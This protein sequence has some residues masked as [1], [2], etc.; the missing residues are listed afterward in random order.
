[1]ASAFEHK[2]LKW[3]R[4]RFES[5]DVPTGHD[6]ARLIDSCHN[7]LA[8]SDVIIT[9]N[10]TV[11]GNITSQGEP[12]AGSQVTVNDPRLD[13]L[14]T[15]VQTNSATWQAGTLLPIDA[16]LKHLH[17]VFSEGSSPTSNDFQQLID[18]SHNSQAHTNPQIQNLLSL[19]NSKSATWGTG[20]DIS[21]LQSYILASSADW[22]QQTDIS[23]ITS[24]VSTNS[25]SWMRGASNSLE[26]IYSVLQPNSAAWSSNSIAID[27]LT[28]T[29]QTNSAI[30]TQAADEIDHVHWHVDNIQSYLQTN[31]AD[32]LAQTDVS[33]IASTIQTYSADWL[34]KTDISHLTSA[35]TTNSAAWLKQTDVTD[36]TSTLLANSGEWARKAALQQ[37]TSF[38][39]T[40][41]SDW[42]GQSQI[43]DLQSTVITSSA[44]WSEKTDT[45][46]LQTEIDSILNIIQ[47]SSSDWIGDEKVN[48]ILSLIDLNT[49]SSNALQFSLNDITTY[50]Q[51]VSTEWS[52][53]TTSVQ[54]NSSAWAQQ[55]DTTT[56]I[57]DV[58]S[59]FELTAD[60]QS[61]ASHVA[62]YSAS[63]AEKTDISELTN[64]VQDNSA[65]W[66]EQT[67]ITH[68]T[69]QLADTGSTVD[70]LILF[71]NSTSASWQEKTDITELTNIITGS[72]AAWM[73]KVDITKTTNDINNMLSLISTNTAR[74]NEKTDVSELTSTVQINSGDWSNATEIGSITDNIHDLTN[75]IISNSAAWLSKTNITELTSIVS[76]YSADWLVDTT[77]TALRSFVMDNSARWKI[78]EDEI[79]HIH[80]HVHD[81]EDLEAIVMAN[82]AKW[83]SCVRT[84]EDDCRLVP[85]TNFYVGNNVAQNTLTLASNPELAW[86]G[87]ENTTT[88]PYII[89]GSGKHSSNNS[90][91]I[92]LYYEWGENQTGVIIPRE[93]RGVLNIEME[94]TS[95]NSSNGTYGSVYAFVDYKTTADGAWKRAYIHNPTYNGFPVSISSGNIPSNHNV[96]THGEWWKQI[97]VDVPTNKLHSVRVRL[98]DTD[99]HANP[100]LKISQLD[101]IE[102]DIDIG[103]EILTYISELS[104]T[105]AGDTSELLSLVQTHSS[106]W[107]EQANLSEIEANLQQLTTEF[108]NVSSTVQNNSAYW[109]HTDITAIVAENSASWPEVAD[110]VEHVHWHVSNIETLLR[111]NSA[112]WDGDVEYVKTVV[113]DNSARWEQQTDITNII[114]NVNDITSYV[115]NNTASWE[116]QTDITNLVTDV[117]NLNI[118]TGDVIT[119]VLSN[120]SDWSRDEQL[121][122]LFMSNSGRWDTNEQ[123]VLDLAAQVAEN[124]ADVAQTTTYLQANTA[125]WDNS[126]GNKLGYPDLTGTSVGLPQL[127]ND[128][129]IPFTHFDSN[130]HPV[131]ESRFT[132]IAQRNADDNTEIPFELIYKVWYEADAWNV[133][134]GPTIEYR[135]LTNDGLEF[136]QNYP[137]PDTGVS[138][139][140]TMGVKLGDSIIGDPAFPND[141]FGYDIDM[142]ADG[143][144][145]IISR[146]GRLTN[147][148]TEGDKP[149]HVQVYR[150]KANADEWEQVGDDIIGTMTDQLQPRQVA[151]NDAGNRVAIGHSGEIAPGPNQVLGAVEIFEF[152]GT[153]WNPMGSV[154]YGEQ[155]GGGF[156]SDF[157]L[158]GAGDRIVIGARRNDSNGIDEAGE[159]NVYQWD[160]NNWSQMGAD[161]SGPT[162]GIYYGYGGA[163]SPA[164]AGIGSRVRIT[165]SGGRIFSTFHNSYKTTQTQNNTSTEKVKVYDWNGT[166]WS[167]MP[168]IDLTQTLAG[169]PGHSSTLRVHGC[170]DSGDRVFIGMFGAEHPDRASGAN[171][172][173]SFDVGAGV[174]FRYVNNQWEQMGDMF[175]FGEASREY[176]GLAGD[177][178]SSGDR[179]II[180]SSGTRDNPG[181]GR[182]GSIGGEAAVYEWSESDQTWNLIVKFEGVQSQELGHELSINSAGNRV[183]IA[184]I[185]RNLDTPGKVD[186]YDLDAPENRKITYKTL[187][188]GDNISVFDAYWARSKN[189]ESPSF[190]WQADWNVFDT[191]PDYT[192][193]QWGYDRGAG[194]YFYLGGVRTNEGVMGPTK[195]G[196]GWQV[197][198]PFGDLESG[199]LEPTE[200]FFSGTSNNV[201]LYPPQI[202]PA[203]N[204]KTYLAANSARW[205]SGGNVANDFHNLET[206]VQANTSVWTNH[207][208]ITDVQAQTNEIQSTVQTNSSDWGTQVDITPV[209]EQLSTHDSIIDHLNTFIQQNSSYWPNVLDD[210]TEIGAYLAANSAR[211]EQMADV[212]GIDF[213]TTFIRTNSSDWYG[214]D[215]D[216][217]DVLSLAERNTSEIDAL[218]SSTSDIITFLETSSADWPT[219]TL[220]SYIQDNSAGWGMHTD[221]TTLVQDV[222][223][224]FD[225]TDLLQSSTSVDDLNTHV[226]TYSAS[227]GERTDITSLQSQSDDVTLT[228]QDNSAGWGMHTDIT[229]LQSQSDDIKTTVQVNSGEWNKQTDITTLQSQSDD[230]KTTVQVNSGNWARDDYIRSAIIGHSGHWEHAAHNP[231]IYTSEGV[232][233]RHGGLGD[234][235]PF[236]QHVKYFYTKLPDEIITYERSTNQEIALRLQ[237]VDSTGPTNFLYMGSNVH[238]DKANTRWL[239]FDDTEHGSFVASSHPYELNQDNLK[240]YIDNGRARWDG[241]GGNADNLDDLTTFIKNNSADWASGGGGSGMGIFVTDVKCGESLDGLVEPLKD[242][243]EV[244]VDNRVPVIS[245]IVD[246]PLVTFEIEWEG[247]AGEWT[248]SPMLSGHLIPRETTAAI[249]PNEE[250]RRFRGTIQLDLEEYKG[251]IATL[252]YTYED[253]EKQIDIQI[254]GDG[255]VVQKLEIVSTPLY[256]QDHYKTGDQIEFV[257]QFD[258][259]DVQSIRLDGNTSATITLPHTDV[260]ND[261]GVNPSVVMDGVSARVKTRVQNTRTSKT[262]LPIKIAAKNR[263]GTEG[264]MHTSDYAGGRA[265]VMNGPVIKRIVRFGAYPTTFGVL[266]TELKNDDQIDVTFELDTTN[267]DRIQWMDN[268]PNTANGPQ[269]MNV[270][271]GNTLEV[272]ATMTAKVASN[273]KNNTGGLER[274]VAARAYRDNWHQTANT[275]TSQKK[276]MVNSQ[277]PTFTP[278]ACESYVNITYDLRVN[279]TTPFSQG[280][281]S[282]EV[283]FCIPSD[284]D[285]NTHLITDMFMGE[286]FVGPLDGAPRWIRHESNQ[287]SFPLFK[288]GYGRIHIEEIDGE[289][290]MTNLQLLS[291]AGQLVLNLVPYDPY[292]DANLVYYI[293][294][295]GDPDRQEFVFTTTPG[296]KVW[297]APDNAWT[298]TKWFFHWTGDEDDLTPRPADLPK[299]YGGTQFADHHPGI[300]DPHSIYYNKL[301]LPNATR[302]TNI[303]YM[304][305]YIDATVSSAYGI[306]DLWEPGARDFPWKW[307]SYQGI[308][309]NVDPNGYTEEKQVFAK[310]GANPYSYVKNIKTEFINPQGNAQTRLMFPNPSFRNN[311]D[312]RQHQYSVTGSGTDQ[313]PYLVNMQIKIEDY[314][315]SPG[316]TPEI[317]SGIQGTTGVLYPQEQY[318]L[319]DSETAMVGIEVDNQGLAPQYTYSAPTNQ[320]SIPAVSQYQVQKTVTRVSGDYSYGSNNYRLD[321]NRTENG[322]TA[323]TQLA[324]NIANVEP[325]IGINTNGGNRMRS[326]GA[327]ETNEPEYTIRLDSSQILIEEPTL[328]A[329]EGELTPTNTDEW[330][331]VQNRGPRLDEQRYTKKISIHDDL[332]RGE[333]EYS[334]S[335]T[336]LAGITTTTINTGDTY[337]IGGFLSRTFA[338]AGFKSEAPLNGMNVLWT[339]YSKLRFSWS[340]SHGWSNITQMPPGTVGDY[341]ASWTILGQTES[342]KN[343]GWKPS[344]NS[345]KRPTIKILDDNVTSRGS[346]GISFVTVE[347]IT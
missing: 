14:I 86:D 252:Y 164:G 121:R 307:H 204:I 88:D 223:T 152:D 229:S 9:G 3:L 82:S 208:D 294:A 274:F 168:E 147:N 104:S 134:A 102:C 48:E 340:F 81:L 184:S 126:L 103:T 295:E 183:A 320:L 258:T 130:N 169:S 30:W 58:Q 246:D 303:Y 200:G 321:V 318:A 309:G 151:I 240:W 109:N 67:D 69:Q 6:F 125:G 18:S 202:G 262:F 44:D 146:N 334:M 193:T 275:F 179:V 343:T 27:E 65:S 45:S 25:A 305:T 174:V 115:Y 172:G 7:S 273:E 120:S 38:I 159:I 257:V 185:E 333:F 80:H 94:L 227:W 301:G 11:S 228:V 137:M 203:Q 28:S 144:R 110:E 335:A 198:L 332:R 263:F 331:N 327:D 138:D 128:H 101:Y 113:Q 279:N 117:N 87:D 289:P 21:E 281:E 286:S 267:V 328:I 140:V 235:Y 73:E 218:A 336:N 180:G 243:D 319:K 346:T 326:G 114:E 329:P 195:T 237:V 161:I 317:T 62:T 83:N 213:L 119:T 287:R 105:W 260:S 188:N 54:T 233:V 84:N 238:N 344:Q 97:S 12:I 271:T 226:A 290:H 298:Y 215:T 26:E 291:P 53:I 141:Q 322:T 39:N 68:I 163:Q 31:S 133:Y 253:V 37:L 34:E 345:D 201:D 160:G 76:N 221:V 127:G 166:T 300:N 177:M 165:Q 341:T 132:G 308:Q 304:R 91:E 92:T 311:D 64:V 100:R 280:Y 32:F 230:I 197:D 66:L 122:S 245:A 71:I 17:E 234:Y 79:E 217:T 106:S 35:I 316:F 51:S 209:T 40:N 20:G 239:W 131:Y 187:T 310:F 261:P 74:W 283:R 136:H 297:S 293:G 72:S 216:I 337:E 211:W 47:T 264:E 259:D 107:V 23:S 111:D 22:A 16:S 196:P 256:R 158:N 302:S 324:V 77:D 157:D 241:Y 266:Q 143:T 339:D 205:D 155:I 15:T 56:L 142:N 285:T 36:I 265:E 292:V 288:N 41:S 276:L 282:K 192:E 182:V 99:M 219:T 156:P 225:I 5:G 75:I 170:S 93:A 222:Q 70:D 251:Q 284:H 248:G 299:F 342:A 148:Y 255:P 178:S 232:P 242:L 145:V 61:S 112:G 173:A 312:P 269:V 231:Q 55:T 98:R 175:T 247:S 116:Q 347:E 124:R 194:D 46:P 89:G 207:T 296:T 191:N 268:V 162:I 24:T 123:S 325:V 43:Q 1:M 139:G 244:E 19:V 60:L 314:Q 78:N 176:I 254:A 95:Y 330:Q 313:D 96:L 10:L 129:A 108:D 181:D 2:S 150:H 90:K 42:T 59:L 250:S 323:S 224:L 85:P 57:Q 278:K 63:W 153:A 33:S 236:E 199:W 52:S 4:S 189:I 186:V 50:L 306:E 249:K 154:I 49:S 206:Y 220:T 13:Q 210:N 171:S 272:T 190:P 8:H 135:D 212:T 338:L 118:N 270:S 167:E 315:T 29:I 277:K 149:H 214:G